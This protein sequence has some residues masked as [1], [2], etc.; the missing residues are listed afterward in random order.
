MGLADDKK[1]VLDTI[2]AY[3]SLKEERKLPNQTNSMSSINNKKEIVPY[4]LDTLK[5]VA[6]SDALKG[7]IGEMFTGFISGVEPQLKS[8]LKKQFVQYNSD[9]S[10]PD[11]FKNDGIKIPVKSIDTTSKLK[12]SPESATGDLIYEKNVLNFDKSAH[13][14]IVN[15]G[16]DTPF[17]VLTINHN[18]TTDE[19]TFKPNLTNLPDP[20]ISGWVGGYID[21]AV[22]I[23]KKEL[24]TDVMDSIYGSVTTTQN[25]TVNQVMQE[26]E[27]SK[28]IN[29]LIGG[30]DSFVILP[31]DYDALMKKAKELV[32]GVVYYDMGCGLMGAILPFSGMTSLI[33]SISGSTDSFATAN[34]IDSTVDQSSGTNPETASENRDTIRDGFFQ[35]LIEIFTV[36]M[37]QAVTTAPQIRMLMGITS[38]FQNNGTVMVNKAKDDMK[39]FKI[40]IK[41]MINEIMKMVAEFIFNLAISLLIALLN[42]V[43]KKIAKEKINQYVKI[44]KSLTSTN[45]IVAAT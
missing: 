30:D 22:I 17:S 26:L 18:S 41:C 39:N 34:A 2:G 15:S 29:Q 23:N 27:I 3:T 24:L 37:V 28:L 21:D 9:D 44:I 42:P 32:D 45:K 31:N 20:T 19:F 11:S 25:K 40:M 16:N 33:Q 43:I 7:L 6:G 1:G 35:K 36:K 14:A 38:S 10:L 8:T 5:T 12:T 4:L 13:D